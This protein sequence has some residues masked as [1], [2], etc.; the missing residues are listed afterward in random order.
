MDDVLQKAIGEAI[1]LLHILANRMPKGSGQRAE[2][3]NVA[4]NLAKAA[5]AKIL[6]SRIRT[7][8]ASVAS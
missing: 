5:G 4:R 7:N 8:D 1:A 6:L 3:L 2:R